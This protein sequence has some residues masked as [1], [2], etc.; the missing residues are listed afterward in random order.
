MIRRWV[1]IVLIGLVLT[2]G[3]FAQKAE[4]PA[5][6]VKV[7]ELQKHLGE[8]ENAREQALANLHAIDGAIQECKYWI[9]RVQAGP[10]KPEVKRTEPAPAQ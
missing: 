7:E 9:K 3:V 8:L 1:G 6:V 2:P 10:G 4:A 5:P